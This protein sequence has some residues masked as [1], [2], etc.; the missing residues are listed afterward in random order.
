MA[1]QFHVE[2]TAQGVL[3]LPPPPIIDAHLVAR[4]TALGMLQREAA[5]IFASHDEAY[6]KATLDLV[7]TRAADR[8]L[9]A[10]ESPAAFFRSALR[11]R[12]ADSQRQRPLARAAPVAKPRVA[13]E[14]N[15]SG[16]ANAI[17]A[18]LLQFD[19]QPD[20]HKKVLLERFVQ[21]NPAFAR[22]IRNTPTGRIAREALAR[23][24]LDVR[25]DPLEQTLLLEL[26]IVT[27]TL[28]T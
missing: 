20:E 9:P 16:K 3:E 10:L 23:W 18:I 11:G 28:Q 22:Y 8:K 2:R 12:F 13:E 17:K 21:A 26:G 14:P 6:L 24:L 25:Q 1:L 5:D 15:D 4:I 27:P 7:E 19:E